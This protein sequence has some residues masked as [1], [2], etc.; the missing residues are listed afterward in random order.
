M[1]SEPTTCA[2]ISYVKTWMDV[3][4]QAPQGFDLTN[5]PPT[6]LDKRSVFFALRPPESK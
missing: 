3:H 2:A 1:R 6:P 5:G 4:E